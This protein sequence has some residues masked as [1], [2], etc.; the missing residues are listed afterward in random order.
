MTC[1][2]CKISRSLKKNQQVS[3][4]YRTEPFDN[5]LC[6]TPPMGWNSWN[7]FK[8]DINEEMLLKMA[9]AIKETGL[10]DA[11]YNY[12]N[13][14]DYWEADRRD[15]E[16]RLVCDSVRFPLGMKS[17]V[18]KCN[19]IG[20]KVGLYSCNGSMTCQ[21]LPAS[22]GKEFHDALQLV[23]W[24]VEYLKYDFCY[25]KRSSSMGPQILGI[26]LTKKGTGKEEYIE[27]NKATLIGR[28]KLRKGGNNH[29]PWM[30]DA[31]QKVEYIDGLDANRGAANF[32]FQTDDEGDYIL[33]IYTRYPFKYAN[34]KKEFMAAIIV[35]NDRPIFLEPGPFK[36]PC[37]VAPFR[38]DIKIT[39]GNN[40]IKIFNPIGTEADSVMI[41]Y[42][43]MSDALLR[44]KKRVEEE[45][46]KPQKDVA[47][48]LC[49]W[50]HGKPWEW[51]PTVSNL[52]RTTGDI[53]WTWKSIMDLYEKNVPLYPYAS[54]GHWNDPDM[55]EVGNGNL[56]ISENRAHFALWCMMASPLL[57]GNDIVNMKKE[58]LAILKNKRVIA[59]D[60]DALGKQAKRIESNAK[61][62]V[63]VRPLADGS[64]ALCILNKSKRRLHFKYD[65][66]VLEGESYVKGYTKK[67]YKVQELWSGLTSEEEKSSINFEIESHDAIIWKLM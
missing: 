21:S 45:T 1:P 16:G 44:A 62:D 39:R 7:Y 32:W 23:R 5:G 33:S 4:I 38:F 53:Q 31:G 49:C 66:S 20:F 22:Q 37:A 46:G 12:L 40:L 67:S 11:G 18:E 34:M 47:Y 25:N 14:D 59:I 41:N 61:Y 27:A 3:N 28:A 10:L 56:T 24:G 36:L 6:K 15:E 9:K 13:L 29:H 19:D 65:L 64:I 50:G 8:Q 54:P 58:H 63:L 60:Q 26:S 55:L 30:P 48:S 35:N 42:M 2:T 17:F 57:L 52:W 43:T 51:G